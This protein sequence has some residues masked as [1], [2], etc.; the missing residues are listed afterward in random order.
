MDSNAKSIISAGA[1]LVWRHQRILWWLFAVN[2][3]L[4]FFAAAPLSLRL[5][6]I[7]DRS[8][9]AGVLYQGFD[10]A[11][12]LE[13]IEHPSTQARSAA[14]V[15]VLFALVYF[16]FSLFLAGGILAQYRADRKLT[17][18][19]FFHNCGGFFWSFARL[20]IVLLIVLAPLA[21]LNSGI[22]KLSEKLADDASI[23]KLG[24]WVQLGG[25]ILVLLLLMAV[26]L[27]FD[28]AQVHMVAQA[29]T[30]ARRGIVRGFHLTRANFGRLFSMYLGISLAGWIAFAVAAWLW[31]RI[32]H[33]KPGLSFLL[34][35]AL[36]LLW[37]GTR[38]WQ[39]AGETTWYQRSQPAPAVLTEAISETEPEV[40]PPPEV[41]GP[42]AAPA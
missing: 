16:I 3:V 18:G 12:V 31:V 37:I 34:W 10:V 2:L 24:F 38:L 6:A 29:D 1:R 41:P 19:E 17:H 40:L 11:A 20:T 23:E 33:D 39:R 35:Q 26:R 8:L 5:S 21:A 4:A 36:L 9:H 13:L 15:G 22:G 28:M 14:I 42:G 27:W 32:P 7:L 30:A 25:S